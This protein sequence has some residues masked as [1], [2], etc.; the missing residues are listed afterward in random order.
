MSILS[1]ARE[2]E[3]DAQYRAPEAITRQMTDEEKERYANMNKTSERITDVTNMKRRGRP[4]KA[5]EVT[6][7]GVPGMQPESRKP[8]ALE[9]RKPATI[10]PEFEKALEGVKLAEPVAPSVPENTEPYID[11]HPEEPIGCNFSDEE[12]IPYEVVKHDDSR[13]PEGISESLADIIYKF[14]RE[15]QRGY[16]AGRAEAAKVLMDTLLKMGA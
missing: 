11:L 6:G 12:P 5:Q 2:A 8:D 9:G 15:Y 13:S 10:N 7:G 4:P 1:A 3:W 14:N 16:E